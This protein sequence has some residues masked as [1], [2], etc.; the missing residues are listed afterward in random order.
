MVDVLFNNILGSSLGIFMKTKPA[1]P[2]AKEKLRE[3]DVPGRDGKL[4]MH[5]GV[6][7]ST[8]IQIE[9]NYIGPETEW[10]K[11]W[12]EAKKWLS[13][14]DRE[15]KF[16]DD[17]EVF[18]RISHV[19][20]ESNEKH[21]NRIGVFSAV[22]VTKDGLGYFDSGKMEY[23]I[24]DL[25]YNC[26]ISSHPIYKITGNG[27]C[28]LVINGKSMTVNV[29]GDITIDTELM[30]AYRSDGTSQNTAVSG[31]Y[32]DIYLSEGEN[33]VSVT[34]GFTCKV[35]PRWRCL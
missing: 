13:A 31:D 17:D 4:L 32:E 22:F 25:P 3:V 30:C 35:I 14:S 7:E 11:R 26:G 2:A 9:F 20:V 5:T 16:S 8:E 24:E 15:L 23:R 12:R 6:Y 33:A 29:S 34:D 28:D 21:G 27:L 19:R 10:G 1:L 18:Y